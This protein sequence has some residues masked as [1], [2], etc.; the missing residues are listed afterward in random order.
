MRAYGNGTY[1][2]GSCVD[3]GRRERLGRELGRLDGGLGDDP[4]ALE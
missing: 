3:V 4:V 1:H 2:L